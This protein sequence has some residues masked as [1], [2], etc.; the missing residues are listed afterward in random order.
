MELN[1]II[2]LYNLF[3][4]YEFIFVQVIHIILL[5]SLG[6]SGRVGQT[7]KD[8]FLTLIMSMW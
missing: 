8:K 2:F 4:L 1:Y 7:S 3:G 6:N 5:K